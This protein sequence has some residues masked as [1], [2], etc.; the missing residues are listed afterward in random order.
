MHIGP[1]HWTLLEHEV[2]M[3]EAN[4]AKRQCNKRS[5][6][7]FYGLIVALLPFFIYWNQQ[8]FKRLQIMEIMGT[9]AAQALVQV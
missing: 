5:S 6:S 9:T 2:F 8:H 1:A 7:F 4:Q 3:C